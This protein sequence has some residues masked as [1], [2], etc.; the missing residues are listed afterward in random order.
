MTFIFCH[1]CMNKIILF[2]HSWDLKVLFVENKDVL[3]CAF[4]CINIRY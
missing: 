4:Y 2:V 1:E 3:H